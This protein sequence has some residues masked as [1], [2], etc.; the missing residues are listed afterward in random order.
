VV[1]VWI[2]WVLRRVQGFAIRFASIGLAG[3][4]LVSLLAV[5]D[6]GSR[7][8]ENV[9]L[10]LGTGWEDQD[11]DKFLRGDY[12]RGAAVL[13]YLSEPLKIIG[14]GPSKYYDPV[15]KEFL[16]GNRGQVFTFYSEVGMLGVAS[17]FWFLFR[18]GAEFSSR[19]RW[20]LVLSV[21]ALSITSSVMSDASIMFAYTFFLRTSLLSQK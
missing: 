10:L 7:M 6:L 16:L 5:T 3:I 8:V 11:I 18:I 21:A 4:L 19:I 13:Y 12:A 1:V 15:S 9:Q 20:P 17:S 14:D 2:Y